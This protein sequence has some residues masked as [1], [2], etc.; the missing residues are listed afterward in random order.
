MYLNS[1]L[2]DE[3]YL[4]LTEETMMFIK[5]QKYNSLWKRLLHRDFNIICD[6]DCYR[7]Y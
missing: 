4:Y 6:K 2:L 7:K 3:I 1:N 5:E